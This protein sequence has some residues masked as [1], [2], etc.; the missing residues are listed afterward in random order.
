MTNG[1]STSFWF[2]NILAYQKRKQGPNLTRAIPPVAPT[3]LRQSNI[4]L[5]YENPN[6]QCVLNQ[7]SCPNRSLTSSRLCKKR[8]ILQD[9]IKPPP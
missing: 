6:P 2:R 3:F 7:K 5:S 8:C 1:V 4:E 9:E